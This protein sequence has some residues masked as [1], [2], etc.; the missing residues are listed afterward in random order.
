VKARRYFSPGQ[1][2]EWVLSKFLVGPNSGP[3]VE[4]IWDPQQ[5]D[6]TEVGNGAIWCANLLF[7]YCR[8]KDRVCEPAVYAVISLQ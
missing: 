5:E 1:G 4:Q 7:M 8:T 3:L 6:N 2:S